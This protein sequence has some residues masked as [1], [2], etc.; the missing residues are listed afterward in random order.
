LQKTVAL[1][2]MK[3]DYIA[4]CQASKNDVRLYKLLQSLAS[5][6]LQTAISGA[7]INIKVDNSG[8]I[9]FSNNHV[10]HKRTKHIDIRYHF[11]RQTITKDK[12][13]GRMV[14]WTTRW[15]T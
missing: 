14:D 10:G 4:L 3:A 15:R 13:K 2:T 7:P 8:C 6:R 11:V 1:S 9:D 5:Q 12:V